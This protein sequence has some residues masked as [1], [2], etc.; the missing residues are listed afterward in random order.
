MSDEDDL[1]NM[2]DDLENLEASEPEEK[3]RVIKAP[4]GYPGGKS[5]SIKYIIPHLPYRNLYCEPFG[6]SGAVL[7]ARKPSKLEIFNDAYSGVVDFYRCMRDRALYERLTHWLENTVN[8]REEFVNCKATWKEPTDPVERAGRWFYMLTYSFGSLGRNWGRARGGA[9]HGINGRVRGSLEKFADVHERFHKVQVENKDGIACL[10]DYDDP[11][12]VFY[13]DPPYVDTDPG[14]YEHKT[15]AEYHRRL[16]AQVFA[17]K[18]FVAVSGYAN[19]L[20][21]AQPWDKVLH[22]SVF[23][24]IQGVKGTEENGLK[25]VEGQLERGQATEKLWI[26]EAKHYR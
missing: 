17:T 9:Y 18:G 16:I 14:I 22:W 2:L 20:W 5:R 26:K 7:L 24:S 4:F 13:L 3:P 11:E 21:D 10:R 8:S 1:L 15:D 23:V 12:A 6:G 19:P 25:E